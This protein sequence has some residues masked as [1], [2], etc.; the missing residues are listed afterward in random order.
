MSIDIN[1]YEYDVSVV[2]PVY[3]TS[4]YLCEAIDSVI[5][6]DYGF[7]KIQIVL[8]DDGSTDGSAEICDR[9]MN[10]YPNNIFVLHKYNEG[11]A[12]A[13]YEGVKIAKGKYVNFLDSDDKLS[14]DSFSKAISFFDNNIDKIDV[15][16]IPIFFFGDKEGPHQLNNKF[17]KGTRII[18]LLKE[19]NIF[20]MHL[21][22]TLV[23]REL[24][25]KHLGFNKELSTAEDAR[26]LTKILLEKNK[27]GVVSEARYYYR[28]RDNSTVS[29][30]EMKPGWYIPY[31]KYF[32]NFVL[33]YSKN[34]FGFI[35]RYIQE[36]V[37]YDLQWKFKSNS[38]NKVLNEKEKNEFFALLKE[39]LSKIEDRIVLRQK[40]ISHE[41]MFSVFRV[42]Y[43]DNFSIVDQ[44]D[45][46]IF[47]Y[48][49]DASTRI[50]RTICKIEFI[51]IKRDELMVE[52]RIQYYDFL[53]DI[54]KIE[55]E[56]NGTIYKSEFLKDEE[57][58]YSL[59]RVVVKYRRFKSRIQLVENNDI[60][61]HVLF[62][63]G[64][65]TIIS[66]YSYGGFSPISERIKSSYYEKNN[67][68]LCKDENGFKV[69][70]ERKKA[71]NGIKKNYLKELWQRNGLG[72]RKAVFVRIIVFLLNLIKRRQIWLL[73]DR[74]IKADDNGLAMFEFI[75]AKKE[76][77]NSYFVID[78]HTEGYRKIKKIGKVVANGS[79]K[80][81]LLLLLSDYILSSH[82]EVEIYNPFVG[83]SEP[84]RNMLSEKRFVFLQHGITKD[85][86]SSWLNKYNKNIYGFVTAAIPEYKSIVDGKYYYDPNN[87]WL[88]GFPRFDR[89]HDN[90]GKE[91][92]IMP[93]WR[94]YLASS[95]I[96]ETGQWIL[97]PN[98]E[99]SK[100][101]IF[102]NLLIN[103][104]RL[105]NKARELGY[106][107]NYFPH[108]NLQDHVDRFKKN[109]NVVFLGRETSYR[110]VYA[111]SSL[112]I[113]DYSSAVFDFAYLHKPV[114]YTQ[115]DK[116][117]F[118]S[119]EHV[120][121]KGYFDY[122]ENGFGE[123]EYDL[124]NTVS[125]IIEYM[126]NDCMLKEK[127]KERI[128]DFF[129]Y[130]DRNNCKRVFEKIM[131]LESYD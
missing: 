128:D 36:M 119:G 98:F 103:D 29:T 7:E 91:I 130:N 95:M 61:I 60:K 47:A 32:S 112:I 20:Q 6:Q 44:G 5:N 31:L 3:N 76:D 14:V 56:N 64:M 115:F 68:I 79:Y 57:P 100:F 41:I 8:V 71:I 81:K 10:N 65:S 21:S 102:Y 49:N 84:Y 108:P 19:D 104:E 106:R 34:E 82:G 80:H 67:F 90:G 18:D 97:K 35:P 87:I 33:D 72:Y 51:K 121:T 118:F 107:I 70:K 124:D 37:M 83:H 69:I 113:T 11:Q 25:Q 99:S 55:L 58:L 114:V 120:Y 48:N 39:V 93:T 122:E 127:Y 12:I 77:I 74:A 131:E 62:K 15:V 117:E 89:L 96:R 110:D 43:G 105:I 50:S 109:K 46:I 2:M 85:D 125:R 101:Y 9:Y 63:N 16:S 126:E 22:A 66:R 116:E 17:S 75:Q 45:D 52:G 24:I 86:I 53:D 30:A 73:S 28:R 42:K 1:D 23:K 27:L 38:I 123:V 4:N 92:T 94:R 129:A 78:K 111:N 54:D 88:T 26:E 40:S 13:R 59:G